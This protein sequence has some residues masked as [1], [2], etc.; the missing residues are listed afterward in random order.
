MN[1]S[2]KNISSIISNR[3]IFDD[4]IFPDGIKRGYLGDCYFCWSL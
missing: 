4:K 3:M 1:I 2:W